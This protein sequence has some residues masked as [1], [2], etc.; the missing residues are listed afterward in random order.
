MTP[1]MD[2]PESIDSLFL[3]APISTWFGVGY[4]PDT[5]FQSRTQFLWRFCASITGKLLGL[6]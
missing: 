5:V 2:A 1:E 3:E 6:L 4:A